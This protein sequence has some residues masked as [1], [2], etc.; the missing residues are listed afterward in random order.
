MYEDLFCCV[1]ESLSLSLSLSLTHSHLDFFF[2]ENRNRNPKKPK[3]LTDVFMRYER[4]ADMPDMFRSYG[5]LYM[6]YV[7]CMYCKKEQQLAYAYMSIT[8]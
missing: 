2:T 7:D 1:C 3:K 4:Y 6:F 5:I 8:N